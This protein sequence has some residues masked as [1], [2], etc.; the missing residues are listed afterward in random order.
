M[1]KQSTAI[2]SNEATQAAALGRLLFDSGMFKDVSDAAQAA[3]KVLAGK[4]V[5]VGPI[6]AM[7]GLHLIKGKVTMAANLIAALILRSGRYSYEVKEH[8]ETVCVIEFFREGK[9]IGVSSFSMDDARKAGLTSNSNWKTYP[10]NMLFA[11][12]VSNGAR[13]FCPDVFSG[14]VYTPD[15]LGS[16]D[17]ESIEVD[18]DDDIIDA[19]F[20]VKEAS[21]SGDH[22]SRLAALIAETGTNEQKFLQYYEVKSFD[23]LTDEQREHAVE[24]LSKRP[25]KN[26]TN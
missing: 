14:A 23:E 3:V 22:L 19:E 9:P 12:A 20:E 2:T 1:A 16:A 13:W 7:S 25:A 10:R 15:E 26:H 24:E 5:G 21:E 4:E 6:Q 18:Q 11:R 8:D 17:D